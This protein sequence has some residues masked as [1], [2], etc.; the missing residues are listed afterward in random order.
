MAA[1]ENIALWH[2]RDISHS[3]VERVILPDTTILLDYALTRL[4]NIIQN[5]NVYPEQMLANMKKTEE[6]LATQKILLAL[7]AKG[8]DRQKGYEAVHKMRCKPGPI[9]NLSEN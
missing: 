1:L 4:T 3:S 9:N 2:E 6:F 7:V 5:L 8:F